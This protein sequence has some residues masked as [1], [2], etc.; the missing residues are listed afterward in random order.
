MAIYLFIIMILILFVGNLKYL[1]NRFEY[2]EQLYVT[3]FEMAVYNVD[4]LLD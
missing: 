4:Y 1:L 2:L 3:H